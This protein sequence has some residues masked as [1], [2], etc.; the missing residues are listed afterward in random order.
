[1]KTRRFLDH[2]PKLTGDVEIKRVAAIPFD[3]LPLN[4]ISELL[5]ACDKIYGNAFLARPDKDHDVKV[6]FKATQI[7]LLNVLKIDKQ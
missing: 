4:S 5:S 7:D 1:M 2:A 3:A 6:T